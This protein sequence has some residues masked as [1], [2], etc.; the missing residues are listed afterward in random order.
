[1]K[2]AGNEMNALLRFA[3][4]AEKGFLP[5]GRG[6]L[7]ETQWFLEACNLVWADQARHRQYAIE[8]LK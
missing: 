2:L 6:A 8:N 7:D 5:N 3:A 1:M 4:Y